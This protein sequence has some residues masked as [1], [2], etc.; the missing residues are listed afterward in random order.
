MIQ[1]SVFWIT[2]FFEPEKF[3]QILNRFNSEEKLDV[4][5]LFS[6]KKKIFKFYKFSSLF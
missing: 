5:I 6:F 3:F 2:L 4:E 1:C